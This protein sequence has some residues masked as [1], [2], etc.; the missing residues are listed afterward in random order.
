MR[1]ICTLTLLAVLPAAQATDCPA[2][3]RWQDGTYVDRTVI[4]KG[5]RGRAIVRRLEG[6]TGLGLELPSGK[7]MMITLAGKNEDDKISF[8][9][10]S[11]NER[12][13]HF[14]E[15]GMM[16]EVP[17]AN[18]PNL[19]GPCA[20][21][22][23][24]TVQVHDLVGRLANKE[25]LAKSAGLKGWMRRNGMTVEYSIQESPGVEVQGYWHYAGKLPGL[26]LDGD[27]QGWRV[28]RR[29][30]LVM[31]LPKGKPLPLSAV[32]EQLRVAKQ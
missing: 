17:F 27:M 7:G 8:L 28:F 4:E 20:L 21:E 2:N 5:E 16:V 11:D 1:M 25:G 10:A 15:L 26:P 19:A 22:D 9:W 32:L 31:T 6:A 24:V 3:L 18:D 30:T 13:S 12:P 23:K 14:A 29:D